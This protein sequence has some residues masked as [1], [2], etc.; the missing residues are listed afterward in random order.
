M[1]YDLSF[2][3]PLQRCFLPLLGSFGKVSV[4]EQLVPCIIHS[5]ASPEVGL[6][7]AAPRPAPRAGLVGLGGRQAAAP[8]SPALP[9]LHH[10]QPG[11]PAGSPGSHTRA[12]GPP[13]PGA[14]K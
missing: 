7:P 12:R 5:A 2:P 4:Q 13:K 10:A 6:Q 8:A 11:A 9:T 3:H 1:L 14:G